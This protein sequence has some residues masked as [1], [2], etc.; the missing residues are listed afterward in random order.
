MIHIILLSMI[1]RKLLIQQLLN[2][3][4]Q[5][6]TCYKIGSKI[7]DENHNGKIQRFIKSAKTNPPTVDSGA[8]SLPPIS[9]SFMYIESSSNNHGNNVFVSFER[10]DIIQNNNIIFY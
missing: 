7:N 8:A 3:Q 6:V 4:T 9:K 2:L 5:V 10:T 1:K